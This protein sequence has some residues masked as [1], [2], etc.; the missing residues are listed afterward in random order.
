MFTKTMSWGHFGQWSVLCEGWSLGSV[1]VC[2]SSLPPFPH[3]PFSLSFPLYINMLQ[4]VTPAKLITHCT[5]GSHRR[6]QNN[7]D[8]KII[9]RLERRDQLV[10]R[11]AHP[12]QL[13]PRR[14]W[15]SRLNQGL[16]SIPLFESENSHNT[17]PSTPS[18]GKS[19]QETQLVRT[20]ALPSP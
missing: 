10:N 1:C 2:L 17:V 14:G 20:K 3:F 18:E 13:C 6:I 5:Q 15:S 12:H 9:A 4:P 19:L 16:F 11:A 7:K 8:N